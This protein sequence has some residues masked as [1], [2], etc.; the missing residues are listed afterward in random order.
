MK[1]NFYFSKK[2]TFKKFPTIGSIIEHEAEL[3]IHKLMNPVISMNPRR[4]L[5]SK[6]RSNLN[7]DFK[8]EKIITILDSIHIV[9]KILVMPFH[10]DH[11]TLWHSPSQVHQTAKILCPKKV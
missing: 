3:F 6:F 5:Y 7:W 2:I 8:L 10:E 11:S 9:I 1:F 4:S